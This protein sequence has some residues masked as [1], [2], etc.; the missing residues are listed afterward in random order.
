MT[1][2]FTRAGQLARHT[3]SARPDDPLG[4][5]AENLREST[6]SALPVFDRVWLEDAPR[7]DDESGPHIIGLV[8]ER[9]LSKVVAPLFAE[10]ESQRAEDFN[11]FLPELSRADPLMVGPVLRRSFE[12]SGH[13]TGENLRGQS[14]SARDVMRTNVGMIPARFTLH[15]A[16]NM[17]DAFDASALPVIDDASGRYLGMI[18]RA[19]IV[20]ALGHAVR[21]PSA[22]GMATPL[23]VWLTTGGVSAGV[24]PVG[25]FLSGLTMGTFLCA[26]DFLLQVL[27][28][29]LN[30]DW[31]TAYASGRLGVESSNGNAFNLLITLAHSLLFL[32][33]MR[34]SPLA[35][36][37][38][39]EHQTVWAIEKGIALTPENVALMPRAHPR[40]GTNLMALMGLILIVFGHL[41]SFDKGTILIALVF[42]YFA[43][44][45][46]GTLMQLHLTTKPATKKQLESGIRAGEELLKKYQQQPNVPGSL[47]MRLFNSGLV[48]SAAGFLCVQWIYQAILSS[49]MLRP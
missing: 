6:C 27:L 7:R 15:R 16:L 9:D 3:P 33:A 20:A 45:D 1:S 41:P 17:L 28:S 36:I 30:A 46:L 26:T 32:G 24:P 19:D 47:G 13:A 4:L 29:A 40:C 2:F 11:D 34:L 14:I 18:A 10:S 25:L 42:I 44:R 38:A 22:G 37:H 39:A 8:E 31:G 49:M 43:W 5:V 35:G 48:M 23:G 21:P 12:Q